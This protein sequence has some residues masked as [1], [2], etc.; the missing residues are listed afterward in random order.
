M[1][2]RV[3]EC[4]PTAAAMTSDGPIDAFR[5]RGPD[6]MRDIH[7][8]RLENGKWTESKAVHND[9]EIFPACPVNGPA[10][11]A[12]GRDVAVAWY[13]GVNVEPKFY[14]AFSSDAG[15]RSDLPFSSTVTDH[16]EG[17]FEGRSLPGWQR[18][19]V[20]TALAYSFLQN[21]RRRPGQ[22][23]LTLPQVRAVIQEC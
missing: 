21:E 16:F 11:S 4:C 6:E 22:T 17:H 23:H 19:V 20:L 2:L 5:N 12:R 15:G 1:D 8:A 13:T 18:H 9:G 10:L 3:C 7:V 14:V